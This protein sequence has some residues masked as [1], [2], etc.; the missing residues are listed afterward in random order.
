MRTGDPSQKPLRELS[1]KI[2]QPPGRHERGPERVKS[3]PRFPEAAALADHEEQEQAYDAPIEKFVEDSDD[4]STEALDGGPVKDRAAK[5]DM[6]SENGFVEKPREGSVELLSGAG[7]DTSIA[8]I[9]QLSVRSVFCL[10][11]A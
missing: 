10:S 2:L 3:E 11:R 1:R 8:C 5:L 7:V 4:A 9:I 6:P